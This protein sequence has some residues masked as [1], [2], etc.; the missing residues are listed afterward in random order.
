MLTIDEIKSFL[1]SELPTR[2]VQ[3]AND[4]AIGNPNVSIIPKVQFAPLGTQYLQNDIIP[5]PLFIRVN[6][7]TLDD[8]IEIGSGS[9]SVGTSGDM[10]Y[11]DSRP[12]DIVVGGVNIGY[13]P[14]VSG[15]SITKLMSLI[16]HAGSTEIVKPPIVNQSILDG[17]VDV[18]INLSFIKYVLTDTI[19]AQI[20]DVS[21]IVSSPLNLINN[22]VL[23]N[24][25]LFVYLNPMNTGLLYS[26]TIKQGTISNNGDDETTFGESTN[27]I[28]ITTVFETSWLPKPSEPV[29]LQSNLNVTIDQ[30]INL[31]EITF[32]V[33]NAIAL[34]LKNGAKVTSNI[35]GIISNATLVGNTIHVPLHNLLNLTTY[36]ITIQADIVENNGDNITT[37]RTS[38]NTN[39]VTAQFKTIAPNVSKPIIGQSPL[40]NTI[41]QS[42]YTN[43]IAFPVSNAIGLTLKDGSKVTVASS[44]SL[45]T[46]GNATLDASNVLHIPILTSPLEYSTNYIITILNGIVE[47]NGDN[48]SSLGS[49][50]NTN[51][52]IANFTTTTKP[53]PIIPSINQSILNNTT[54]VSVNLTEITFIVS[55][56]FNLSLLDATKVICDKSGIVGN[57]TLDLP[58]K[59]IHV[60]II[61]VLDY[62]TSYYITIQSGLIANNGDNINTFGT[63]TNNSI[64]AKITTEP[65]T[66]TKPIVGQSSANSLTNQSRTL[67]EV[68]FPITNIIGTMMKDT[69]KI[70]CDHI[71]IIGT[72]TYGSGFIH[73]PIIAT[74]DYITNY[75]ITVG[76][77][78]IENH[79][80]GIAHLGVNANTNII[81]TTFTTI[82][83]PKPTPPIILQSSLN[84]AINQ[85][86]TLSE[87]TFD[88]SN[89]IDLTLADGLKV[90]S[91]PSGIAGTTSLVG[92]IIHIP[93]IN[94]N[95]GT[96]YS[97]T[98]QS[99]IVQNNSDGINTSGSTIN[100]NSITAI[101]KTKAGNVSEPI[102]QQSSLNGSTNKEISLSEITFNVSNAIGTVLKNGSLVSISPSGSIGV[103]T[104]DVS[105]I[106]HVPLSSL[107][108]STTYSVTVNN[109]IVENTGDGTSSSGTALNTNTVITSF[110]T[111]SILSPPTISASVTTS[112]P[113]N[114]TQIIYAINQSGCTLLDTSKITVTGAN[115]GT[116]SISGNQLIIPIG[117][118]I[119]GN[120]VTISIISGAIKNSDGVNNSDVSDSTFAI[121]EAE[122]ALPSHDF[123]LDIDWATGIGSMNLTTVTGYSP[124]N[125]LSIANYTVQKIQVYFLGVKLD[126]DS[127]SP[128]KNERIPIR[129]YESSATPNAYVGKWYI[130]SANTLKITSAPTTNIKIKLIRLI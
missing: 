41:E 31:S 42:I 17:T 121:S 16:L 117:G 107:T 25:E 101:F 14:K 10:L 66:V 104:L 26:I 99:G 54:V 1:Y 73:V 71:G 105:N 87:I 13:K 116:V 61:K 110:T 2:P 28:D 36:N 118:L 97:V 49:A 45:I 23:K 76:I 24:N 92:N 130:T 119:V 9:G 102:V 127:G 125:P 62:Y 38:S 39:T 35:S 60:P 75:S 57:A 56:D 95:V 11:K 93:L 47:N 94:L 50:E 55:N 91:S 109:G 84:N 113:Q 90:S 48:I 126:L 68:T 129:D 85:L 6:V 69:T 53:K 63:S 64:T 19:N 80:N 12:S 100:S 58:T 33:D 123:E 32:D 15:I 3:I 128:Q 96:T 7:G 37:A 103:V 74:L 67:T 79:G 40:N 51:T 46:I 106:I 8:W 111:R 83:R 112:Y 86:T 108:Y 52:I 124:T 77:D 81:T 5:H 72:P 70:T 59:T 65:T 120:T 89:S 88:V 98:I 115:K 22:V 44:G 4:D 122:V 82:D 78:S 20:K 29:I 18:S 21:K 114:T 30:P 34:S 27:T 43:E